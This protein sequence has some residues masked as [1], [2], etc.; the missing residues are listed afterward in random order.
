VVSGLAN[1]RKLLEQIGKGRNDL[2]FVEVMTCPGGCIGGGGQLL[3]VDE[4]AVRARMAAL[5]AIDTAGELRVAHRNAAVRRLYD[6]LLG[7]PASARS[8][9]LLHTTYTRRDVVL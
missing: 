1:A 9:H 3:G 2:H 5:Y 4:G 7:E 8:H 6:E